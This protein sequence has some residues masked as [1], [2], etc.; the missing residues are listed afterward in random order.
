MAHTGYQTLNNSV[1][2][3][4]K[5]NHFKEPGKASLTRRPTVQNATCGTKGER[6]AAHDDVC[7]VDE[8]VV[9]IAFVMADDCS[10]LKRLII[11]LR[12]RLACVLRLSEFEIMNGDLDS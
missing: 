8:L 7:C 9:F 12:E 6:V 2:M 4:S 5:A 11:S 10:P 1:V 3:L